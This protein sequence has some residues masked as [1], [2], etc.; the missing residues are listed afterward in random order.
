M[1]QI[2]SV[3][4]Y[5]S[6]EVTAILRDFLEVEYKENENFDKYSDVKREESKKFENLHENICPT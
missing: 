5:I 1:V 2:K 6:T 3:I 4:Y